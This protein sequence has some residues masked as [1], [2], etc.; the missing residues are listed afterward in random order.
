M[1]WYNHKLSYNNSDK[2]NSNGNN[3]N[4]SNNNNSN[5]I[6]GNNNNS[7]NNNNKNNNNNNPRTGKQ[8]KRNIIRFNPPFSKNVA[9]KIGRYFLNL[10][11]KHFARDHKSHKIFNRNNIKV[12]Y[13]FMQI[14]N[15]P[16]THTTEKSFAKV[17]HVTALRKQTALYKE[18]A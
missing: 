7:N 17:E 11:D 16:S 14:L 3:N 18:N 9:K 4:N 12:S 8:L 1:S 15:H 10:A 2:Y 13:S 5:D 6:R